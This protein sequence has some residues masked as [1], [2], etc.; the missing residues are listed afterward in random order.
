MPE[1]T[2]EDILQKGRKYWAI[3][4]ETFILRPSA[5]LEFLQNFRKS[6]FN[7]KKL[8]NLE[9]FLNILNFVFSKIWTL[10]CE[11]G[12]INITWRHKSAKVDLNRV[13]V[14]PFCFHNEVLYNKPESVFDFN[15]ILEFG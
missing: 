4:N 2:W 14:Q 11:I 3:F 12:L 15:S 9:K 7:L 6:E 1:F 13:M 5:Q 10:Q 8:F